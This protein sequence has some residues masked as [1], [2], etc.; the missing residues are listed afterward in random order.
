MNRF[1]PGDWALAALM[2]LEVPTRSVCSGP[3]SPFQ[4]AD[5][6]AVV[7]VHATTASMSWRA[8]EDLRT[9]SKRRSVDTTSSPSGEPK[10]WRALSADRTMARTR[11]PRSRRFATTSCPTPPG[12]GRREKRRKKYI[13]F[14]E[15]SPRACVSKEEGLR[16]WAVGCAMSGGS[17][18][19]SLSG[20]S[21]ERMDEVCPRN[22][23][24]KPA[25]CSSAIKTT[26]FAR[27]LTIVSR[28]GSE[29]LAPQ[30][31]TC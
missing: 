31:R 10:S 12:G 11:Y 3:L 22:E 20:H 15:R 6:K 28:G 1:K 17:V 9:S 23:P 13:G 21:R 8:L 19:C 27:A 5:G 24:Q 29:R 4:R 25:A 2:R 7:P 16:S 30:P 14:S 18:W 26:C